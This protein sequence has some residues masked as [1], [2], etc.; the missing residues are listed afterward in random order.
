VGIVLRECTMAVTISVSICDGNVN[1]GGLR[2]I[3]EG[4]PPPHYVPGLSE[5]CH[6]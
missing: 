2:Q 5:Y 3:G 4:L 6:A 1:E